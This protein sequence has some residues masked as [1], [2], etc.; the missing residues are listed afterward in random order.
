M[1]CNTLDPLG[2]SAKAR[3]SYRAYARS[4]IGQTWCGDGTF[5]RLGQGGQCVF[6]RRLKG[7]ELVFGQDLGLHHA[8]ASISENNLLR[9]PQFA[10]VNHATFVTGV[11]IGL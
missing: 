7:H 6:D 5:A 11:N 3:I 4:E 10:Y 1:I 9:R 8:S 2:S